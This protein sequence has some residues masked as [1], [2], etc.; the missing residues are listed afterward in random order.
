MGWTSYH[1]GYYKNGKVDRKA[2]CDAYWEEGL[3]RGHFK[4]EKSAMVGSVYYAA[5]T[6]LL[7]RKSDNEYVEIPENERETFAVVFLTSV[8]NNDYY[9][10]S[11]KDMDESCGPCES[12]CPISILKL[13]SPIESQWANEW[14]KRCEEYHASKKSKSNPNNLPI[15]T[16]IKWKDKILIKHAPAYQFKTWFWYN[17]NGGYVQKRLVKEGEYEVIS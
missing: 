6:S 16:K 17:G 15:G 11:Y 14:R 3:N 4:V 13:L 5:I 1:A 10:F 8:N 2:E 7:K 9:N 12:K